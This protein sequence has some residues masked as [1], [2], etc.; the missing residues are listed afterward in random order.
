MRD[1][2]EAIE[3]AHLKELHHRNDPESVIRLFESQPSLH[4]S[5]SALSEYVKA[6]V[7]VDRLDESEL[8]KTLQRGGYWHGFQFHFGKIMLLRL[9]WL[10]YFKI[11]VWLS[12]NFMNLGVIRDIFTIKFLVLDK[13]Y[14]LLAFDLERLTVKKQIL[15]GYNLPV[16]IQ[17]YRIVFG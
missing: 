4:S 5:P 16:L 8:L 2:E 17:F 15:L 11:L 3:V 12:A 14:V 6:L 7:K 10:Q 13:S 9:L 1:A